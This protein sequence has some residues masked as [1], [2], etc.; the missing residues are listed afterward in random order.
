MTRPADETHCR[1]IPQRM[2]FP[3]VPAST[4]GGRSDRLWLPDSS[5]EILFSARF[6]RI[7]PRGQPQ[8]GYDVDGFLP[9]SPENILR[10][11]HGSISMDC[12]TSGFVIPDILRAPQ[13]VTTEC[14]LRL[15]RYHPWT[16]RPEAYEF[17]L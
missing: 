6:F 7:R 14:V 16:H 2:R 12:S 11:E 8:A 13:R 4:D 10:R 1:N 17:R 9:G 5:V 15:V 3:T